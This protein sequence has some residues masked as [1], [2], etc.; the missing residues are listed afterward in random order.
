MFSLDHA[1]TDGIFPRRER[2]APGVDLAV[3]AHHAV[4]HV[5]H[6]VAVLLGPGEEKLFEARDGRAVVRADERRL[7]VGL[8]RCCGSDGGSG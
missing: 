2:G 1:I 7:V 6:E 5:E 8:Q 4:L 3:V